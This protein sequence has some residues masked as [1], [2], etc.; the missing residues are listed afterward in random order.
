VVKVERRTKT[1]ALVEEEEYRQYS[2]P[3]NEKLSAALCEM[4]CRSTAAGLSLRN[5]STRANQLPVGFGLQAAGAPRVGDPSDLRCR[6]PVEL[7]EVVRTELLDRVLDSSG[8]GKQVGHVDP[9][10][11]RGERP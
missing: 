4:Q 7:V 2:T 3:L 10:T 9:L 1:D 6:R 8:S 5:A 11:R